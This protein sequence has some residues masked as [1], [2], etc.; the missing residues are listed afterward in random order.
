MFSGGNAA[1][2]LG[3]RGDE[4]LGGGQIAG[5]WLE[6]GLRTDD[7]A[8]VAGNTNNQPSGVTSSGAISFD[9]RSTV[10]LSDSWGE[11]RLGRDFTAQ[12][13]NRSEID[14]FSNNGVGTIQPQ[15]GS[16]AGS[17]SPRASN[18]VG[19]FL[20]ADL[21][22]VFGEVQHFL[23]ANQSNLDSREGSGSSARIGYS[24][25]LFSVA[26]AFARTDYQRSATTG[27]I[28]S[29]NVGASLNVDRW[30]LS[31]GYYRD[32]V[33]QDVPLTATGYAVGAIVS[34]N[35]AQLKVA[36]SAYGTDAIGN[37]RARKLSLG[38]VFSLSKRTATY[39]TYAHVANSGGSTAAVNGATTAPDHGSSGFEIGVR[40]SF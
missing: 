6:A 1:S 3:F 10:S 8:G 9:R 2:R 39:A 19:Y 11:L 36:W 14:P 34:L 20:P 12:Y 23:A 5:F 30:L 18:I 28:D 21:A 40:H 15:A 38:Y 24:G 37:P 33:Q 31:A 7:G 25:G 17:T 26:A 16:I 22:G 4:D 13:R 29:A 32:R 35:S 27:D